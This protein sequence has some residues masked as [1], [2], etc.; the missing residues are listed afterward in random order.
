MNK[1]LSSIIM[2]SAGSVIGSVVTWK[3]VEE[4]YKRIAQEE[5]DSVK[6][7]FSKRHASREASEEPEPPTDEDIERYVNIVKETKYASEADISEKGEPVTMDGPYVI[8]PDEFDENGYDTTSLRY[9]S[10][11]ILVDDAGDIVE[12]VESVV[13][14]DSLEHFGEYEADS[15]FVRDDRLEIDYEILLDTRKYVDVINSSH[16]VEE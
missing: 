8:S 4:K 15:V 12:D 7:A 13:G 11:G 9:Y 6:E 1:T 14:V 3:L 2:F 16:S 10:D 5:I